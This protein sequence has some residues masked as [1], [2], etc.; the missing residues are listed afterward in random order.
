V[1]VYTL[2][3]PHRKSLIK[4]IVEQLDSLMAIGESRGKAKDEA[5]TAG[6]ETWAFSTGKIHSF[7]TRQ[8]YQ[9]HALRFGKWARDTYGIKQFAGLVA[10]ADELASDYLRKNLDEQKSASTLQ[11]I[12]AALRML[13]GNRQLAQSVELPKRRRK[14]ITR[15]R[16]PKKH[17]RQFQPKNWPDLLH[18]LDATGLR[19]DEVKMLK[20]GDICE[21][22]PDYGGQTTVLVRNGK[23]GKERTVLVDP[24]RVQDVLKL[25]AGRA[26]DERVFARIPKH[27]DVH[28][29]R[30]DFAQDRYLRNAPDHDLPPI[31]KDRLSPKDYDRTA[32][33]KV[34]EALGHNRRSVVL[35]HY[36]R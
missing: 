33:Q 1:E 36:I 22:N 18:F 24:E 20:A 3:K 9:E 4:E 11:T 19:R 25:K 17:D 29:H 10:R 27:L 28:S 26:D 34:T 16:G 31:E 12:R 2:G 6:E 5:R 32:A 21:H 8:V 15:S 23:G 13:F 30:R 35:G 7:K 14:Q